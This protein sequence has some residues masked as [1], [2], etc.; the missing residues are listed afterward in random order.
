M[1]YDHLLDLQLKIR[2]PAP[3]SSRPPV[4]SPSKPSRTHIPTSPSL[5]CGPG[6]RPHSCGPISHDQRGPSERIAWKMGPLGR[7]NFRA[8]ASPPKKF[9]VS[10]ISHLLLPLI[11]RFDS[12]R[13]NHSHPSKLFLHPSPPNPQIRSRNTS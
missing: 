2:T 7:P 8:P 6:T 1:R 12:N 13:P 11:I 9:R 5:P 3:P 4:T 10:S